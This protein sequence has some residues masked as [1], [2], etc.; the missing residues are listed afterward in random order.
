MQCDSDIF[1]LKILKD[2]A[3]KVTKVCSVAE[4]LSWA[5]TL[6]ALHFHR[7]QNGL[8]LLLKI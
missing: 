4:I 3:L 6:E 5:C 1:L 8:E 7:I 2:H